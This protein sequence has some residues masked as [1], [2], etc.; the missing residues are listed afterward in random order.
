MATFE[1]SFRH[2]TEHAARIGHGDASAVLN[3]Q[4]ENGLLDGH[5]AHLL[6]P[7]VDEFFFAA[8]E[9]EIPVGVAMAPIAGA[10][11]VA[12]ESVFIIP[13]QE[14]GAAHHIAAH[15]QFPVNA[16]GHQFA[17]IIQHT[18]LDLRG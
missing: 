7:H 8:R 17:I 14:I 16:V 6:A 13:G 10:E 5:G 18:H 3:T 11:P 2:L 1:V 12:P 15:A 4:R 9:I